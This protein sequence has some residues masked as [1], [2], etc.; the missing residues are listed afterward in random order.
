MALDLSR[1]QAE[2][3]RDASVNASAETL[4]RNLADEIERSK[5]NEAALDALVAR[6]RDNSNALAA[7]VSANTPGEEP[8]NPN[9]PGDIGSGEGDT[10]VTPG[11]SEPTPPADTPPQ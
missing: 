10:P 6:L 4:I 2:I 9:Q 3:E 5:G 7:A 11:D 1:L 8:A